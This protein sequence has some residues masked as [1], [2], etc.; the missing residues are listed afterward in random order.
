[1]RD[2]KSL[3]FNS[4]RKCV[5][6]NY[7]LTVMFNFW[8]GYIIFFPKVNPGYIVNNDPQPAFLRS[9]CSSI[10]MY[11]SCISVSLPVYLPIRPSRFSV[12]YILEFVNIFGPL[13]EKVITQSTLSTVYTLI[14]WSLTIDSIFRQ[15][16]PNFGPLVAKKWLKMV[17]A[18]IWTILTDWHVIHDRME[19]WFV[20]IPFAVLSHMIQIFVA[21]SAKAWYYLSHF[22]YCHGYHHECHLEII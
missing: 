17:V 2:R 10:Y 16:W 3:P 18:N 5:V 9:I 14:R 8:N 11:S 6:F 4:S 1:M 13:S 20:Y 19:V 21:I 12:Q 22:T 7:I 15:R